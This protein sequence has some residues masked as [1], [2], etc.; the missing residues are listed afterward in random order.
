MP[1]GA[2]SEFAK[3]GTVIAIEG[4]E[5]CRAQLDNNKSLRAGGFAL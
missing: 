3:D 5:V 4:A 2:S 1:F